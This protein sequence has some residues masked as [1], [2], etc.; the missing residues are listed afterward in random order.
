[1][2]LTDWTQYD[3]TEHGASSEQV[4]N[5]SVSY[6]FNNGTHSGMLIHDQSATDSP[7]EGRV[8]Y[9]FRPDFDGDS[10]PG[11]I[12]FRVQ[13][14][15]NLYLAC[16]ND[17][18]TQMYLAKNTGTGWTSVDGSNTTHDTTLS[19]Y[20]YRFT[21]W[22]DS[23]TLNVRWEQDTGGGYSLMGDDMSDPA[24]DLSDGGGIGIH[25][26]G[27]AASALSQSTNGIQAVWFDD[28]EVF[29]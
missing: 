1:M 11:G 3:G 4:H 13:D 8:E 23:G 14:A 26:H 21:F 17:D 27:T 25:N 19:W 20:Q 10:A 9:W 18:V 22:E 16:T 7:T 29:W 24:N 6:K 5:G 2:A 15:N 12:A 28:V